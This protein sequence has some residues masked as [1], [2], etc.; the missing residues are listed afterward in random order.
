MAQ[1]VRILTEHLQQSRCTVRKPSGSH[2]SQSAV[3]QQRDTSFR[4]PHMSNKTYSCDPVRAN[5]H[6]HAQCLRS[7]VVLAWS[8]RGVPSAA[9]EGG[10]V[11]IIDPCATRA[12]LCAELTVLLQPRVVAR[13][14]RKHALLPL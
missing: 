5:T 14:R 6:M 11:R 2:A 3:N 13:P 9:E 12:A 7:D 10:A 1:I 4:R 8:E